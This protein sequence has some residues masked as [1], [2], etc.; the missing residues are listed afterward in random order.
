MGKIFHNHMPDRVSFDEPDLRPSKYMTP[1]LIDREPESFYH[2]EDLNR[3]LVQVQQLD[4]EGSTPAKTRL[5]RFGQFRRRVFRKADARTL[6]PGARQEHDRGRLGRPRL[7]TRLASRLQI[8]SCENLRGRA[9]LAPRAP[10]TAPA[11]RN[12]RRPRPASP[13]TGM[14]ST[15]MIPTIMTASDRKQP[16]Y[17]I[18]LSVPGK[19]KLRAGLSNRPRSGPRS[20]PKWSTLSPGILT[21][22]RDHGTHPFFL[23]HQDTH[24]LATRGKTGDRFAPSLH[25][26]EGISPRWT[27]PR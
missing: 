17:F 15:A 8:L 13:T 11:Q 14:N 10:E 22:P 4:R 26:A 9:P 1:E 24:R 12:A 16:Q 2:D 27:A 5:L 7:E 20:G 23:N 19:R 25:R 3:E 21:A 18:D 6:G